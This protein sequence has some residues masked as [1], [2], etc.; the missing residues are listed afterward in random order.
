MKSERRHELQHNDLAEWITT[1]YERIAPYKNTVLGVGLLVIVLTIGVA[2]WRSHSAAQSAEA[3]ASLGVPVIGMSFYNEQWLQVLQRTM[4]THPGTAAAEWADVFQADMHLMAGANR[5]LTDKKVGTT[6]LSQAKDFY[7]KAAGAANIAGVKEQAMFGKARALESL[8]Q[9]K[10][11][12]QEAVAAY[13]E[14]NKAF[15]QGMYKGIA[16]QRIAQLPKGDALKFYQKLASYTPPAAPTPPPASPKSE[17]DKLGPLPENP[18]APLVPAVP[19]KPD[20]SHGGSLPAIPM[21]SLT[22]S[23]PG[24]PEGPK[25]ELPRIPPL[26]P[27]ET[28]KPEGKK[29]ELPK[30]PPLTPDTTKP[31][32]P[33]MPTAEPAKT[34]ASQTEVPKKAGP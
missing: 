24:K 21:P 8:I 3:W 26:M 25:T 9:N 32:A 28:G 15:P 18:E 14:L 29:T 10:E 11:Q 19:V 12:L 13:E 16:E 30:L 31:D 22:P 1:G 2:W 7:T 6:I 23:E 5:V 17:L 4:Q 33:K 20:A 27:S 34:T